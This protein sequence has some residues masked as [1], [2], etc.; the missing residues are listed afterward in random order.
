[1]RLNTKPKPTK[2][3]QEGAPAFDGSPEQALRRSVMSCMLW[4]TEFYEDGVAI[5]DRISE[6]AQKV[7]PEALFEI[8]YEARTKY[9]L[10]HV[11]LLLLCELIRRGGHGVADAVKVCIKR[12][13]EITELLAVY[14]RNGRTP[15]S[16]QLKLGLAQAFQNFDEYQ[17]A[18]YNR[19]G[20]ITLKDAMFMARPK[21][22]DDKQKG[23]FRRLANDELATPDTW[24]TRKSGGKSTVETFEPLLRGNKLGYLA[25]LRNLRKMTQDGVD[26]ELI[27]SAILARRN[28]EHVLPFR[29]VAA[30]RA[31]PQLE[32]VIDQALCEAVASG[33]RMKG[34]TIVLVDVSYSMEDKL[35]SKSDLS[36]LDAACTLASVLNADYRVFSFSDH[37]QEVPARSGMAGV[38]AIRQSQSHQGTWLGKAVAE[39]NALQHDRLIVITD[40]QSHDPVPDP[41][42]DRSY[43]INVASTEYGVGSGKWKRINGFSEQVLNYIRQMESEL[44]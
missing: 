36:R 13:D 5:S 35:S 4:E 15:L 40:E 7:S 43:M 28:A 38:D 6:L 23:L 29:Y 3:T 16:K 42:M 27:K 41:V 22:V 33:P 2:F 17:L 25:L 8:S 44:G 10:R 32:P 30:A 19:P 9:K 20:P 24:E 37:V 1:M 14:W 12:P 21:P 39:I 18:K 26:L 31:C 11:P 34:K